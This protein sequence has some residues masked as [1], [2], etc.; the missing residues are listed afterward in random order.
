MRIKKAFISFFLVFVY[1]FGFAHSVM[2][3]EHGFYAEHQSEGIS[4]LSKSHQYEHNDCESPTESCI[5]HEDHCDDGLLDL[6]ICL[7]SD[8]NSNH[9]DC[10][11]EIN[12][13]E[14]QKRI[15]R[16]SSENTYKSNHSQF[17]E[18]SRS[19]FGLQP[20]KNEFYYFL[21]KDF[22]SPT[23]KNSP[24]RGPPFIS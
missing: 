18:F 3:H 17:Y 15:V 16:N 9:T 5:N 6:L 24:I 12:T 7:F 11:V 2:P 23:I 1:S 22:S 14:G 19:V 20:K 13:H 10:D 4:K 8:L 21:N